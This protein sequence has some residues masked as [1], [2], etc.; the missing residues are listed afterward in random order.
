[1]SRK[2]IA[3]A[4]VAAA[5]LA[6]SACSSS[7]S[8]SS[9]SAGGQ[10]LI[11]SSD[12]PLQG[13]AADASD[14]TNKAIELYLKQVGYKAGKFT[15]SFKPYDD[16]TAAKG[17]WDDATCAKNAQDHV[18]NRNEVAVMGTYNSGCAKIIAPVLNQDPNGPMLMVSHANTNPGLTKTWDPGEPAIYQPSGKRNYA[19]VCTT[20][21]YQG[22]AAAQFAQQ[23]LHAK[24]VYVLNDNETYGQGVAQAFTTEAKKLG[25]T[26]LSPGA[27]GAAWDVKQP[28]YAA[29]FNK[30][31]GLGPDM[32]YLGGIFD[33]NGGQLVKD[34]VKVL[35]DN[36]K[37]LLMGPDGFTGY[38]DLLK[39][40]E[41]EGM[42]LTFAGL[43]ADLLPK[44][45]VGSKFL[46]DYQTA[47]GSAPIGSYPIYGVAAVQVILAAI[48]KSDGT[49][50]SITNAV[51]SGSGITIPASESVLGKDISIDPLTGD[52]NARDITVE[53]IKN[54]VETTLQ[55]WTV[56]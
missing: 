47:Y 35:G 13:S 38:P 20:D 53:V 12:L 14:S 43:S 26:V 49:R 23:V 22:S 4:A 5:S 2:F 54:H 17:S 29:L 55:A 45:G 25:M 56:Q 52:V 42:Y 33:N 48:A 15:V 41:A 36:S 40:P 31:K 30:I 1:M 50:A 32:V 51:F 28:N 21:D 18:A 8:S 10:T 3:L 16:S 27:Y 11:I 46:A 9:A 6:L 7:S 19:R 44:G 34:K 24:K 37:V 39:L